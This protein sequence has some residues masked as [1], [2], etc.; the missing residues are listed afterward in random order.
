M[1][2]LQDFDFST[3]LR[4]ETSFMDFVNEV[5]NILNSAVAAVVNS[6]QL[7]GQTGDIAATTIFTPVTPWFFRVSVYVI[8][9]T[10]GGGTLNVTIGWT[11]SV[12]AKTSSPAAD[13]NLNSTANGATGAAFIRA[14]SAAITYTATITAKTGSPQYSLFIVMEQ[15]G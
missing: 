3:K 13:I 12:G 4:Q 15:L 2:K 14:N 7:T 11:D 9:T 8:C 6:V 10:A 5:R 1:P